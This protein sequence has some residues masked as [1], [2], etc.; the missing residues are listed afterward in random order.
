M[1]RPSVLIGVARLTFIF[2]FIC[3]VSLLLQLARMNSDQQVEFA[4]RETVTED[5]NLP[6][7]ALVVTYQRCGSSFFGELFDENKDAFYVYEPVDAYYV[8]KYATVEGYNIPTDIFTFWNGS[9]RTQP[10]DEIEGVASH[11]KDLLTCNMDDIPAQF[12]AHKYWFLF[13]SDYQSSQKNFRKCIHSTPKQF[14]AHKCRERHLS[15]LCPGRLGQNWDQHTACAHPQST[16]YQNALGRYHECINNLR[17]AIKKC[18]E[19][20]RK[21]CMLSKLRVMKSV[22]TSMESVSLLLEALPRLRVIHLVR[23]PRGVVLSRMKHASFRG[24]ASNGSLTNEAKYFCRDV[25]RELKLRKKL[26]KQYPG[27]IMEVIYE[28]FVQDPLDYSKQ[29][30]DF[31]GVDFP[32]YIE[33]FVSDNTR[34]KTDSVAKSVRWQSKLTYENVL[35]IKDYCQYFYDNFKHEWS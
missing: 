15:K 3:T 23:D 16:V 28:N 5:P 6:K 35:R 11:L 13:G 33:K 20:S 34:G 22:R 19:V 14:N 2:I 12:F 32:E 24:T 26:E 9:E 1:I 30:Y 7:M 17:T 31:L 10:T 18:V 21:N 27:R 29:V 25:A 8:A 4:V